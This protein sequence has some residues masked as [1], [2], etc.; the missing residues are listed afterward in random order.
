MNR[1][2]A[3]MRRVA[4][5]RREA[6]GI[7]RRNQAYLFRHNPRERYR[8][9]DDKL[10]TKALLAR[11]GLPFPATHALFRIQHDV[12]HLPR[13]VAALP[14]FVIKP[15]CGAGGAGVLVIAERRGERFLKPSGQPL[16]LRDLRDHIAD[17]VAGAFT[18]SQL[19][20]AAMV[21]DRV[22]AAAA[23]AALSYQGLADVRVVCFHG[24]PLMA[25]LRLP[26]RT[27]D[28]RA[29]LHM[30]GIGVGIDLAS[31]TTTH[32]VWRQRPVDRHPD[33]GRPLA[34]APVPAWDE[35]LHIAAEAAAA[36][37][38]GYVG[39]DVVVD[40]R[41]GPLV[42]ELNARPGLGIQLANR[43]GLRP[44]LEAAEA[45]ALPAPASTEA[46]I[47]RG[48]ALAHP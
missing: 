8:V 35:V 48:I 22:T 34:G 15:A 20:D 33:L 12:A 16:G 43:R 28:G 23:L 1:V 6:L 19:R 2:A 13:A 39:V 5:L 17:I 10:E 9:V 42:L 25:M 31:G 29:N 21:E 14:D 47:A 27:S 18:L 37:G 46:R 30:G 38:L 36:T 41:R 7:N 26:T 4:R 3:A 32:A 44:I 24:M 45:R 11:A 40:A